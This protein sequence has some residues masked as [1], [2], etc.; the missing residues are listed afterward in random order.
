MPFAEPD[1]GR[2]GKPHAHTIVVQPSRLPKMCIVVQPSR[3]P[4]MS[5][6]VQPSRLPKMSIAVQPSRL[7]KMS[8]V[9]QPSRLPKMLYSRRAGGTPAPQTWRNAWLN[10]C[11][12]CERAFRQTTQRP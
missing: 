11:L 9:V 3:L 10:A 5:I 7:P 6:V 4:K 8:M 12:A 2:N 1:D